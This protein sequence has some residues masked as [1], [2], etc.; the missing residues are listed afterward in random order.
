MDEKKLLPV[1][2]RI[3]FIKT[4]ADGPCPD[5]THGGNLYAVK[6]DLG[7]VTGHGTQEGHWV[8]WDR[9]PHAFGAE[10]GTEFVEAETLE[11][12]D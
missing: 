2:T 9:W 3:K 7:T 6:G 8:K 11:T 10:Y 4:L 12:K 5:A 1:G